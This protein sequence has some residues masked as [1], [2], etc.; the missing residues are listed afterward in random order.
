MT[1]VW[2]I[3]RKLA[4]RK[5]TNPRGLTVSIAFDDNR[6]NQYDYAFRLLK[7]KGMVGTFY[8]V[9]DYIRDFSLNSSYMDIAELHDLQNYGCEIASHSKTHPNFIHISDDQIH[10]ECNVSKHVLQSHGFQVSNFAY[11]YGDTNYHVDSIVR[12]Y[13]RSGR[14]AYSPPYM[15]QLP[16]SRFR[17]SGAPGETEGAI[18]QASVRAWWNRYK[19][20]GLVDEAYDAK[21][22][23]II[24]FHN[25]VPKR[26]SAFEIDAQDFANFLDYLIL[27]RVKT[28]TVN[29]ALDDLGGSL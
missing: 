29:Q 19:R 12:S 18:K 4:W 20:L 5:R 15:M 24:L 10:S 27:K 13:Y 22:W 14:S 3:L 21:G 2:F 16:T 11:P 6:Q 1:Y 7:S 26:S 9:T 8:V 28:V 23:M 25:V 17:L